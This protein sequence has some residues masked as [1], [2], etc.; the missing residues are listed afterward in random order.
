MRHCEP[1]IYINDD[2]R[3]DMP[4]T[5][6]VMMAS[7]ATT[8]VMMIGSFITADDDDDL[9]ILLDCQDCYHDDMK[10]KEC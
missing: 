5:M 1:K 4:N 3:S 8:E 9:R 2:A 10:Q 7:I 6:M